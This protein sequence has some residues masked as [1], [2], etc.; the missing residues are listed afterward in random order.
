[1]SWYCW[2]LLGLA[3]W[4]IVPAVCLGPTLGRLLAR[5]AGEQ[6]FLTKQETELAR[7]PPEGPALTRRLEEIVRAHRQR[8]EPPR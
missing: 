4:A 5:R 7:L 8:H 3:A 6:T 1:M 2:V